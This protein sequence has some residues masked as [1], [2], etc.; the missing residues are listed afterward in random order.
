MGDAEGLGLASPCLH[1]AGAV[2]CPLCSLSARENYAEREQKQTL[3]VLETQEEVWRRAAGVGGVLRSQ[4]A[5]AR[6]LAPLL[7]SWVNLSKLLNLSV[8]WFV[9]L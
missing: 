5:G 9:H 7:T 8:P 4:T 1:W 3:E 6:I 2:G